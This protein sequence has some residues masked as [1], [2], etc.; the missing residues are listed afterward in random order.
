MASREA[1]CAWV[2]RLQD[3]LRVRVAAVGGVFYMQNATLSSLGKGITFERYVG[4][5]RKVFLFIH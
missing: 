3:S 4:K 1:G 2:F 5:V